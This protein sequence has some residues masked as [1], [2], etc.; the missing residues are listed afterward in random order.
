MS[1][2]CLHKVSVIVGSNRAGSL[3]QLLAHNLIAMAGPALTFHACRIDDLPMYC[4]DLETTFPPAAKRFKQEIVEA[5]ALLVL[6]PEHNRAIPA[7]LKN[8][9]DWA[10]R[11]YGD[12][13]WSG[14][15]VAIAGVATGVIGTAVAQQQLRTML[16]GLGALVMGGEVYLSAKGGLFDD[17]GGITSNET[18]AFLQSFIDQFETLIH[19]LA[20]HAP[21]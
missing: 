18:R 15:L 13:S 20:A 2:S 9:I 11:P 1:L 17:K 5:D 3:N 4:S 6:T 14:K 8:A 10:T 12:N 7:L 21:T 19:R 16:G